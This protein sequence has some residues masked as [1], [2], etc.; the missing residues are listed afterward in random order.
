MAA[1]SQHIILQTLVLANVSFGETRTFYSIRLHLWIYRTRQNK[2]TWFLKMHLFVCLFVCLCGRLS[3]RMNEFPMFPLVFPTGKADFIIVWTCI[4]LCILYVATPLGTSYSL[5]IVKLLQ[6]TVEGLSTFCF[7]KKESN[8]KLPTT[9]NNY[10]QEQ[11]E[12][13][14][15][16]QLKMI[17]TEKNIKAVNCKCIKIQNVYITK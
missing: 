2:Q 17:H 7:A 9:R 11:I 8:K 3:R 12:H 13:S 14:F 6:A 10:E 15:V 1:S 4:N 16:I 5:P